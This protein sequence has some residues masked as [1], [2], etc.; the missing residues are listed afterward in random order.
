VFVLVD[1]LGGDFTAN[2]AA[3]QTIVHDTSI[4]IRIGDTLRL[5]E[6][7]GRGKARA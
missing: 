6:S 1:F 3:E 7:P 2:D 5:G 4:G